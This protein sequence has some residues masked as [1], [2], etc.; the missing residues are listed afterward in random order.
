MVRPAPTSRT[1]VRWSCVLLGITLIAC[2]DSPREQLQKMGIAFAPESFVAAA[3]QG[4]L[5]VVRLFLAAGID[6]EVSDPE[7]GRALTAA[8]RGPDGRVVEALLEAGVEVEIVEGS[9]I[10]PLGAAAAAGNVEAAE[11]LIAAGLDPGRPLVDGRT[12]LMVAAGDG[13]VEL[14]GALLAHG[15]DVDATDPSGATPLIAAVVDGHTAV[16]ARLLAAG[17]DPDHLASAPPARD[18]GVGARHALGIAAELDDAAT[19]RVLL[20]A[21]ADPD[22]RGTGG[23]PAALTAAARA[24]SAS[25]VRLLL[26][27]GADRE[28]ADRD[29]AT[30]LMLAAAAGHTEIVRQLVRAGAD[31]DRQQ[32]GGGTALMLAAEAGHEDVVEALLAAGADPSVEGERRYTALVAARHAGH[33]AIAARLRAALRERRSAGTEDVRQWA[34]LSQ[35]ADAW[36]TPPGWEALDPFRSDQGY[37]EDLSLVG[38]END[39]GVTT[40]RALLRDPATRSQ[41]LLVRGSLFEWMPRIAEGIAPLDDDPHVRFSEHRVRSADGVEI[42]Y[43]RVEREGSDGAPARRY[44]LGL[45]DLGHEALVIDAGGPVDAFDPEL[46]EGFLRTLHVRGPAP[47]AGAGLR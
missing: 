32:E 39:E 19:A 22:R 9:G 27:R 21:G 33:E 6:P 28:A 15:V 38:V 17:A 44:V 34:G 10:T 14:V 8:A 11:H 13:H 29:G 26:E 31:L 25:V 24:G 5:H 42:D 47:A 36:R 41:I 1:V 2:G 16:A 3:E 18:R 45:V 37:W 20:D 7:R 40:R 23:G 4:D 12:P 35:Y 43:L 46:V 30:A